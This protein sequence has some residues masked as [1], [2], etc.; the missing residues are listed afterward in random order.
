MDALAY[1][2]KIK[3]RLNYVEDDKFDKKL[4]VLLSILNKV[5]KNSKTLIVCENFNIKKLFESFSKRKMSICFVDD[6]KYIFRI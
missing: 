2:E 5:E 3:I 1:I 4:K 6:S